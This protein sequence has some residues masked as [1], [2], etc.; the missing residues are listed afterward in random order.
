[1]VCFNSCK[2]SY[3]PG[4]IHLR[5]NNKVCEDDD[6]KKC[7]YG[8]DCADCGPRPITTLCLN[9][10]GRYPT[11]YDDSFFSYY[12]EFPDGVCNDG[13]KGSEYNGCGL[14]HDCD[15]CGPRLING[16]D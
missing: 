4:R 11:S 13:G 5:A 3:D 12:G 2:V 9:D 8:Y 7:D 15:D 16:T 14:G 1:M 6:V 10:C